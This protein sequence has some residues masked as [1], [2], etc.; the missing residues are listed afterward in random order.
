MTSRLRILVLAPLVVL[1]LLAAG[2]GGKQSVAGSSAAPGAELVRDDTLAFISIDTDTSS[3][4]WKQLDALS[5]KFPGRDQ[6]ITQLEQ[7]L[8]GSGVSYQNDIEPALGPEFDVVVGNGGGSAGETTAIGL[9]KPDDP[10]KFKALVAKSDQHDASKSAI[11]KLD[12]G[13]Y[14]VGD[15][16]AHIDSLLRGNAQPLSDNTLYNNS[17]SKLPG[18]ALAKA[19]V[20]GPELAKVVHEALQ[21]RGGGALS[22]STAGLDKLEFVSASLAAESDGLRLHGAAQGSGASTLTGSAGDYS[23]KLLGEAPSDTF[24]FLSFQGGQSL[25][26][27]LG[28]LSAPLELALGVS[29]QD[30]VGLF[31][32]ENALWVRPGAVIPEF[33]AILQPDDTASGLATLDKL[34]HKLAAGSGATI[35]GGAEKTLSFG[36]QFQLHYGEVAGKLVLTSA[37]GGV[38]SVGKPSQSLA[39]SAD[40]KEAASSAG[41]PASN[42][43]FMYV[44]LKNAI[45]LIEGFAAL[46]GSSLPTTTTENLR[47][48]RSFL[49]W[50]AGSGDA[51]TFDAF[52]EIK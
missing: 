10:A 33:T 1:A 23:S 12:N 41:M 32:N 51:R 38:T 44:D 26:A 28:Q 16:Q 22:G 27:G 42:G 36:K 17:L 11:K 20:N 31:Q 35:S 15:T 9:T 37:P 46:S 30:V 2:C 43:G 14:A 24:A 39:D 3:G 45:P 34:L 25:E 50:S 40:F 5:Q 6:A 8:G 18:D 47:P 7:S 21:Q 19:Y 49:E 13:W 4:Q 52:L 48:L 29:L